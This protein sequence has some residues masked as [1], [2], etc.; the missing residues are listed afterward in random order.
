MML[1]V[2]AQR[3]L[4]V[5]GLQDLKAVFA[6]VERNQIANRFLIVYDQHFAAAGTV[7][8]ACV[9]WDPLCHN[10]ESEVG[11]VCAWLPTSST[12]AC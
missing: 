4:P 8:R 9:H 2:K 10:A 12:I 6:E 7:L 1:A 3:L 11:A 5:L